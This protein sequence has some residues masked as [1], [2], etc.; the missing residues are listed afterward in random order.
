MAHSRVAATAPLSHH[1]HPPPP[2]LPLQPI[3]SG[4]EDMYAVPDQEL[5]AGGKNKKGY[6]NDDIVA[7]HIQNKQLAAAGAPT[8]VPLEEQEAAAA[9]NSQALY[10]AEIADVAAPK[11]AAIE[12]IDPD[13]VLHGVDAVK[14][15]MGCQLTRDEAQSLLKE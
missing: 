10:T 6:V 7:Q 13:P 12:R 2:P 4:G 3:E 15:W 5:L 8:Y 1:H 11:P 9:V 14:A